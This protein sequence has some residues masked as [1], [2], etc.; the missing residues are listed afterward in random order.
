VIRKPSDRLCRPQNVQRAERI[1]SETG[2]EVEPGTRTEETRE[3]KHG[4]NQGMPDILDDHLKIIYTILQTLTETV[5]ATVA[6]IEAVNSI[7]LAQHPEAREQ[8]AGLIQQ[9]KASLR[10]SIEAIQKQLNILISGDP[11]TVR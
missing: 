8:L 3:E 9:E 2:I 10:T 11:K 5:T 7:V 1:G 6:H 4:L